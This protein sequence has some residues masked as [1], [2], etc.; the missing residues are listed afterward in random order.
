MSRLKRVLFISDSVNPVADNGGGSVV[1]YRHLRR[2]SDAGHRVIVVSFALTGQFARKGEFETVHLLKRWW[3]PPLRQATPMLTNMRFGLLF[4]RMRREL[5]L[6]PANDVVLGLL[7]ETSNLLAL[8]SKERLGLPYLLFYH[9]DTLFNRYAQQR[10]LEAGITRRILDGSSH[11]FAVSEPLAEQLTLAG[12]AHISVLYPM[13]EGRPKNSRN[14]R[15]EQAGRP[16]LLTAGMIEPIHFDLLK[17]IGQG[18]QEAGGDF[19]C[20]AGLDELGRRLLSKGGFVTV[21]PRVP[22]LEDLFKLIL[23][24]ADILVVFYSF[25]VR[26]EPRMLTS[27]PSKLVEYCHLGLPVLIVAPEF[28]SLGQWAIRHEW[29][30][31]GSTDDPAALARLITLINTEGTWG[32]CSSQAKTMAST[33]FHPD[34]IHAQLVEKINS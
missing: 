6:D 17:R 10:L 15:P 18:A 14:Y 19:C 8:T 7:G 34:L 32:R 21:Q 11:I 4:N 27:F 30:G 26:D 12:L 22:V 20:I 9:D 25:D 2:L 31:Y 16:R 29:L 3:Y 33:Q 5:R 23:E 1:I 28:S 24:Q 13:P